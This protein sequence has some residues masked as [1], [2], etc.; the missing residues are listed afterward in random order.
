MKRIACLLALALPLLACGEGTAPSSEQ[1]QGL[2]DADA[3]LNEAPNGLESV[4]DQGLGTEA[5][6]N[7]PLEKGRT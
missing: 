3:M 6:G 1:D 5:D 7:A 2:N 4:D